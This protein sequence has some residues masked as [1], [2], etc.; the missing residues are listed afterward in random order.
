MEHRWF[1]SGAL[2]KDIGTAIATQDYVDNVLRK[3]D[4]E[5]KAEL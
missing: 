5:A 4:A 3:L 1:M 2:D